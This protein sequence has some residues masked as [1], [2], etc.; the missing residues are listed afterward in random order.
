MLANTDGKTWQ[1]LSLNNSRF[2]HLDIVVQRKNMPCFFCCCCLFVVVV[3]F[4]FRAHYKKGP[5]SVR[6]PSADTDDRGCPDSWWSH[7]G[8]A[9]GRSRLGSTHS[10]RQ[11]LIMTNPHCTLAPW[12]LESP[13]QVCKCNTK[14]K[15]EGFYLFSQSPGRPQK[16]R[17]NP[18]PH[19]L[20]NSWQ[21]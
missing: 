12:A 6:S 5:I 15:V 3:L 9:R 19:H 17:P 18:K 11:D 20:S 10:V 16:T 1:S 21:I 13:Q 14:D 4:C 2:F 7:R 8:T